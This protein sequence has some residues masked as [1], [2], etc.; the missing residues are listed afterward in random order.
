MREALLEAR[1]A[2]AEGEVPVG[3]VVVKDGVVIGRG[4]NQPIGRH[5]PTAHAEIMAMRAAAEALGNYRLPGCELYVT[6]EPCVMCSGAMMHARLSRIIYGATDPKTG[7]C[8]SVVNVFESGQLNHHAEVEGG[9]LAEDCGQV[10][11]D[12][13]AERRA[14]R[15]NNVA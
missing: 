6:L 14:L 7:A 12:F 8:G 13:F 11:K 10:L 1:R 5:D 4:Y 2:W 3:A 15:K 9:L